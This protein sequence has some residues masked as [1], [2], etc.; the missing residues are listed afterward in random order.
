MPEVEELHGAVREGCDLS[1]FG[2]EGYL[3]HLQCGEISMV[4]DPALGEQSDV[5]ETL[6]AVG[7]V[8]KVGVTFTAD[9]FKSLDIEAKVGRVF[10]AAFRIDLAVIDDRFEPGKVFVV[11][12]DDDLKVWRVSRCGR[13]G[14][15]KGL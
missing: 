10:R 9:I 11:M 7:Y 4:I 1:R 8:V 3:L 14:S 12:R 2:L 15:T 13:G 5:F 6:V